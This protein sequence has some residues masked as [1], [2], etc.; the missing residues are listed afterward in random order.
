[1]AILKDYYIYPA[2]FTYDDDG[3]SIEF[4]DLPGCLSS[5][6]TD[7]EAAKNAKEVLSLH[8]YDLEQDDEDA[9]EPTPF[10]KIVRQDNQVVALIDVWMP[11][12]RSQIKEVYVKKTLTVPNSLDVLAKM[13]NV[14]FSKLLQEALKKELGIK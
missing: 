7:E 11:Y 13:N 6:D 3:I 8:I 14:N 4:P 12:H 5:A 9:P 2:I 1:M 10:S